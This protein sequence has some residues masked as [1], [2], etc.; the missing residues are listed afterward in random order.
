LLS[1]RKEKMKASPPTERGK[2]RGRWTEAAREHEKKPHLF[3]GKKKGTPP[4]PGRG[5]KVSFAMAKRKEAPDV[6][7]CSRKYLPSKLLGGGCSGGGRSP[8]NE[9]RESS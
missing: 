2:K 9:G 8:R 1:G 7:M 6:L 5:R 3:K 4:Q